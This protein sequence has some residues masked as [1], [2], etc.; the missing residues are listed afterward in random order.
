MEPSPIDISPLLP[1]V[2]P[3]SLVFFRVLGLMIFLPMMSGASIPVQYKAMLAAMVAVCAYAV[4]EVRASADLE[5]DM[6]ELAVLVFVEM[7]IGMG[8]GA[9][10]GLPFVAIEIAG[11]IMGYQMGFALAQAYNPELDINLNSI[12]SMLFFICLT[13][14]AG[15]GGLESLFIALLQTFE[16]VPVGQVDLR[17]GPVETLIDVLTAGTSVA[18]SI[19]MPVLTVVMLVLIAIGFIMKTMPQINVMSVGFALKI[20]AGTA[21][22]MIGIFSIERAVA[23]FT[24]HG[25]LESIRWSESLTPID[26]QP[27][28]AATAQGGE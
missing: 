19:A 16:T 7:T 28:P 8:I 26:G 13:I 21:L 10:A 3:W 25:I 11:H 12:G 24:E 2:V 6:L 20:V 15:I 1:H 4:P 9:I 17:Q 5:I 23:E 14:F 18:L 22:L 27:S